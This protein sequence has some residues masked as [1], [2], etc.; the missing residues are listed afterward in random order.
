[1][2]AGSQTDDD[3]AALNEDAEEAGEVDGGMDDTDTASPF[4]DLSGKEREVTAIACRIKELMAENPGLSYKDMVILLR[5]PSGWNEV[6]K[7]VLAD[8]G[9]PGE[10][11]DALRLYAEDLLQRRYLLRF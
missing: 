11:N 9:I 3:A 2:E 7:K 8:H 10:R 4:A 5:S 1:M 6:L